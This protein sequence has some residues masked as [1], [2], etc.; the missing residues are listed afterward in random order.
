VGWKES[1]SHSSMSNVDDQPPLR[2]EFAE[3]TYE[4]SEK[5]K[6]TPYNI[7][8]KKITPYKIRKKKITAYFL[9]RNPSQG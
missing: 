2:K 7:Q 5:K 4:Y 8:K 9:I 6:I 3:Q 1:A